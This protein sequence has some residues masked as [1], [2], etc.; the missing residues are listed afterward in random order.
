MD[1]SHADINMVINKRQKLL[2]DEWIRRVPIMLVLV[3]SLLRVYHFLIN[4]SL[5]LDEVYLVSGILRLDLD[6]LAVQPL[7][8][9]Q[10]APLGFLYTVKFCVLIFGEN[11]MAFRLFPLICGIASLFIFLRVSRFFLSFKGVVISVAILAFAPFLIFH[12]VEIKQYSSQLLAT[13]V[14]LWLYVNY[15]NKANIP[16]STLWGIY[17]AV[18]IWFSYSAIFVLA[19]IAGAVCLDLIYK[20][21]WRLLFYS[22]IPFT[23]WMISFLINYFIYIDEPQ[24]SEWL[25]RW[26]SDRNSFMPLPP[27]LESIKWIAYQFYRILEYPLGLLWVWNPLTFDNFVLRNLVQMPMLPFVF[28][29]IGLFAL[30]RTRIKWLMVLL[31]PV[32][33]VLLASGLKLYPVFERL[34][35]F[36]TPLLILVM[37]RGAAEFTDNKYVRPYTFLFIGLF[38]AGPVVSSAREMIIPSEMGG[39]KHTRYRETLKYIDTHFK[40]GDAIYVYWNFVPPYRVYKELGYLKYNAIQGKDVREVSSNE[41]E[42]FEN[43][44]R[45]FDKIKGQQRVWLIFENNLAFDIGDMSE[46]TWYHQGVFGREPGLRIL[47]KF[48]TMGSELRHFKTRQASVYLFDLTTRQGGL[49]GY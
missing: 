41:K 45:D 20:K 21:N 1:P 6:Q 48:R 12:S 3:G 30:A 18:I 10:Q 33:I 47:K 46:D 29:G 44:Q 26:F 28:Y 39:Y 4:R 14:A 42:Y 24:K 8:Y 49:S 5:W 38:L 37:A 35:V 27:G 36:I 43:L 17:G 31:F 32:L 34:T 40:E 9:Q 25:I 22:F 19:G 2:S 16:S 7:D 13:V 23:L 11:E 15:H